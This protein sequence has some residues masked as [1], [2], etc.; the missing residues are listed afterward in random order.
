MESDWALEDH[1]E[2]DKEEDQQFYEGPKITRPGEQQQAYGSP[3]SIPLPS[4]VNVAGYRYLSNSIF[5]FRLFFSC[6]LA[7]MIASFLVL[8]RVREAI[9]DPPYPSYNWNYIAVVLTPLTLLLVG[10]IFYVIANW[11]KVRQEKE[12]HRHVIINVLCLAAVILGSILYSTFKR[13]QEKLA[14]KLTT[15]RY[16]V[17]TRL[18]VYLLVGIL[19]IAAA[20]STKKA[21]LHGFP[22]L[23]KRLRVPMRLF[24]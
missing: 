17:G 13:R 19:S 21:L 20:K 5:L 10:R 6:F 14:L 15:R 16:F 7:F 2:H 23:K 1:D 8:Y 24:H 9:P 3:R 11:E 18:M 4:K 22:K 12:R